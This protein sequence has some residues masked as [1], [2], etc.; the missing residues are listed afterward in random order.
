[1]CGCAHARKRRYADILTCTNPQAILPNSLPVEVLAKHLAGATAQLFGV[2]PE[3]AAAAAAAGVGAFIAECSD[4]QMWACRATHSR[5]ASS[6]SKASSAAGSC[7]VGACMGMQRAA[8]FY[9]ETFAVLRQKA[10]C[11]SLQEAAHLKHFVRHS[12]QQLLLRLCCTI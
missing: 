7:S 4:C 11:S 5:S 3:A 1:M 12:K 9:N 6:C 10:C 8:L 2:D